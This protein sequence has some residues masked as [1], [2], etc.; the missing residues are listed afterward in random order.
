MSNLLFNIRFGTYHWQ[1]TRDWSMSFKHNPAQAKWRDSHV[2]WHWFQAYCL[3][4]K[5]L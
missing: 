5:H 2:P 4:G 1:L 3:F